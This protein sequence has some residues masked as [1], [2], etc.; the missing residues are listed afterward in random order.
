ML[1]G[2]QKL[3]FAWSITRATASPVFAFLHLFFPSTTRFYF[4]Y[5]KDVTSIIGCNS[6]L[7]FAFRFFAWK[8]A[9]DY[10]RLKA[11]II[12]AMNRM[13]RV[14]SASSY[15]MP[16]S[17]ISHSKL[18]DNESPVSFVAAARHTNIETDR[19]CLE[20]GPVAI[21]VESRYFSIHHCVNIF[22]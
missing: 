21:G 12:I 8:V 10:S 22:V 13:E 11:F 16:D 17:T 3:Y 9:D 20:L 6:C 15:T 18:R 14:F 1:K 2:C 4:K 7:S 5:R 19:N